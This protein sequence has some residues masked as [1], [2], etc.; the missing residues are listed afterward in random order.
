MSFSLPLFLEAVHGVNHD[1]DLLQIRVEQAYRFQFAR[2]DALFTQIQ[3]LVERQ[4]VDAKIVVRLLDDLLL[5]AM[6][7]YPVQKQGM[8]N[9]T[10]NV[11]ESA[12]SR[13]NT[14]A[15]KAHSTLSDATAAT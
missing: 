10:Q 12:S 14:S 8:A 3:Q 9:R 5:L 7:R 1:G 13:R 2:L 4:R 15:S 6:R 11:D